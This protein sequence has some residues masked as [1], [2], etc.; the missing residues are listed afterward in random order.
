MGSLLYV[1]MGW[2]ALKL[3]LGG[4]ELLKAYLRYTCKE[5][6]GRGLT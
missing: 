5:V 2:M 6:V 3:T 1:E 4:L